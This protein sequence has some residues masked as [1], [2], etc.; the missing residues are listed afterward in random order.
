MVDAKVDKGQVR[1][2]SQHWNWLPTY[3]YLDQKIS[4]TGGVHHEV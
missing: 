3:Q 1:I 4:V 2:I